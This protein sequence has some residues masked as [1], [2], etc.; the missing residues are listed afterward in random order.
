MV[1]EDVCTIEGGDYT[2]NGRSTFDFFF[3]DDDDTYDDGYRHAE[4][5]EAAVCV[6]MGDCGEGE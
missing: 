5:E 1:N 3:S 2:T 4:A 6:M